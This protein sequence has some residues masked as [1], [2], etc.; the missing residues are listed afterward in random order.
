MI[1]V[2]IDPGQSGSL[3]FNFGKTVSF[4]DFKSKGIIGYVEALK[5]IQP[6]MVIVEKVHAMPKQGVASTFSFGQRFGEIEGMLQTLR[7]S[8]MLVPPQVWQKAC[9]I[10]PKSHKKDIARVMLQLYPEASLYGSKGGLL[11]GRS[12]ALGLSHYGRLLFN[13]EINEVS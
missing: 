4:Q 8:Y 7:L 2:G 9:H 3:C 10:S 1:I 5:T 13:K 6:D 12:D 11:D